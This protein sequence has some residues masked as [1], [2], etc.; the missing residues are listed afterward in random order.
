M[1]VGT[2]VQGR[3]RKPYTFYRCS[4]VSDCPR[5]VT[6]SADVAERV[7]VDAVRDLLEG[8]AGTASFAEGVEDAERDLD[9]REQELDA[10]VRAF[11]GLDDVDAARERL[12]TLREARDEAR[13]RLADVQAAAAPAVT[14]TAG[15][16][17]VLTLDE[18]R[19]LIRAVIDRADVAP[20]RGSDRISVKPRGQ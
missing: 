1:V 3:R 16:W 12:T 8:M 18:Q 4:P 10:A 19:A 11:S 6:V 9:R 20:G 15:D 2:T 14:V 7:V 13:D 5:R 17:D